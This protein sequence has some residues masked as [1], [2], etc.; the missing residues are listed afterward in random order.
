MGPPYPDPMPWARVIRL[1]NYHFWGKRKGFLPSDNSLNIFKP[2]HFF[3]FASSRFGYFPEI[4]AFSFRAFRAFARLHKED[5]F[6]VI[7]DIETLGYG[8]LFAS[9]LGVRTVSTVHHPLKIDRDA[10]LRQATSWDG[11]YYNVAF[12]PLIMQGLTAR[13]VDGMIT[14]SRIGVEEILSAFRVEQDRV[15]L[16]YTGIDLDKFTPSPDTVRNRNEILFVGN[17]DDPRKGVRY[18]LQALKALSPE[19]RL[20]IVDDGPP[21]KHLTAGMIDEL[22]LKRRVTF[23]GKVPLDDLIR[24]YRKAAVLVMPSLFEGFGLPAAEAMACETP[25]VATSAGSLPEVVG[26]DREGG[27][28]APPE[29]A[30]ALAQAVRGILSDPVEAGNMGRRARARVERLFGWDR[31]AKQTAEVYEKVIAG[32]GSSQEHRRPAAENRIGDKRHAPSWG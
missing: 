18:L 19:T 16:V 20:T 5:P 22:G 30:K 25:V 21:L 14:S 15:H 7:H 12:Y 6:D 1:P 8:L 29:D 11:R 3:E 17:A 31:T 2:L 27:I 32:V 10:H 13:R 28:L 24:R 9:R 4:F 26:E 23:T